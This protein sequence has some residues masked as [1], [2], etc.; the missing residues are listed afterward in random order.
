[1]SLSNIRTRLKV[2]E[3]HRLPTMTEIDQV[4]WHIIVCDT[5]L[6]R[7]WSAGDRKAIL[8]FYADPDWYGAKQT[9]D[10]RFGRANWLLVWKKIIFTGHGDL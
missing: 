9:L 6:R 3:Q 8:K 1:M 10:E 4:I 2:V 5:H 7:I